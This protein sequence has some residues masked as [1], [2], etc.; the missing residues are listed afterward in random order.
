VGIGYLRTGGLATHGA[1]IALAVG[2]LIALAHA[3]ACGGDAAT[4]E[5]R[6]RAV[7]AAL[8]ESAEARDAGAMKEHVSEAY[9]DAQGNDKATIGQVVALH[10]LRNQSV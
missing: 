1:R 3:L 7:L 2:V 6:I 8:E 9:R 5:D 4:P 10:L